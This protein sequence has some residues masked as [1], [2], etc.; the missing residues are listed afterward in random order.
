[1]E[2]LTRYLKKLY[3][4][5]YKDGTFLTSDGK[6]NKKLEDYGFNFS[7]LKDDFGI[8]YLTNSRREN[9]ESLKKIN[10]VTRNWNEETWYSWYRGIFDKCI[11]N[12]RRVINDAYI[13]K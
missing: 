1:M 11:M 8:D 4:H 3:Y 2:F 6:I 5:L 12:N 7:Y 9:I 13:Y 10:E